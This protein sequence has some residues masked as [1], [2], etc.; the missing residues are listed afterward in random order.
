MAQSELQTISVSIFKNGKSFVV[1]EGDVTTKENVYTLREI[2]NALFGTLWFTGLHADIAQVTGKL[3]SVSESLERS[4]DSFADLLYANMGR[5]LT[6]TTSD[7][8][9][10]TGTVEKFNLNAVGADAVVVIK[11]DGGWVSLAARS[12]KTLDFA[13][14]PECTVQLTEKV[15]KPLVQVRFATGGTQPLR[16]MY[17][18]DGI[19][20]LPTYLL[21]LV[22]ETEG[23]LRLQAEVSNDAENL[24]NTSVNFVVGVPNFKFAD[25]PAAL[26]S[27]APNLLRNQG[28]SGASRFNNSLMSQAMSS[29]SYSE[30]R[31]PVSDGEIPDVIADS[32]EDFYFYTVNGI[33]LD[34]GARAY[35]PLFNIPVKIRHFYECNLSS[36]QDE[37]SYHNYDGESQFLF[38]T[39]HCNV[40]HSIELKNDTQTPFTTG[41]V[42]IVDGKTRRP[43]SEDLIK[44]TGAE[45]AS[46]IQ[47]AQAPDIRVEEQEKI[48]SARP[49]AKKWRGYSYSL[50]TIQSDVVV[51]NS[52]NQAV[53]LVIDRQITGKCV[54]ST[55]KYHSRQ[56][57]GANSVNPLDRLKF[58][59]KVKPGTTLN[60][61]YTYEIYV[62][63]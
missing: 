33:T 19:S 6:V 26:I 25:N 3:D 56:M 55:E 49:Q 4:A 16:V 22:S 17:L 37:R 51:V 39:K 43:I 21:E 18:Q 50:V 11:T 53:D 9:I 27:F 1:K 13:E 36:I 2:P 41:S 30:V 34:K 61:S 10:Y 15:E 44:Y 54:S 28:A 59:L 57:P 24:V 12:V 31:T 63:D 7:D 29:Y 32:S 38:D 45:Q 52:K 20:W 8:K 42:M 46:S 60:F 35:Y 14:K 5:R 58:D 40:F 23:Q 62:Q 48:I 47:L